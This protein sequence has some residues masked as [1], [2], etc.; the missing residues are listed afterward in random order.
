MGNSSNKHNIQNDTYEINSDSIASHIQLKGHKATR[1][2]ACKVVPLSTNISMII[3][4][5]HGTDAAYTTQKSR[6]EI[7]GEVNIWLIWYNKKNQECQ[8]FHQLKYEFDIKRITL[9]DIHSSG[10]FIIL[11]AHNPKKIGYNYNFGQYLPSTQAVPCILLS[12]NGINKIG[13][14]EDAQT[15]P[16][17]VQLSI[18]FKYISIQVD[19]KL[20]E[21]GAWNLKFYHF[22]NNEKTNNGKNCNGSYSDMKTDKSVSMDEND[23]S[24]KS[25][26]GVCGAD[27]SINNNNY[28]KWI[29]INSQHIF[30]FSDTID[31]KWIAKIALKEKYTALP[32]DIYYPLKKD[33]FSYDQHKYYV[34][35]DICS[36][37]NNLIYGFGQHDRIVLFKSNISNIIENINNKKNDKEFTP[38]EITPVAEYDYKSNDWQNL[39]VTFGTDGRLFCVGYK[40]TIYIFE[41]VIDDNNINDT[42]HEIKLIGEHSIDNE[43]DRDDDGDTDNDET[44]QQLTHVEMQ[45]DVNVCNLEWI[46]ENTLL[47]CVKIFNKYTNDLKYQLRMLQTLKYDSI[48]INILLPHVSDISDICSLILEMVGSRVSQTIDTSIKG[49]RRIESMSVKQII[50][51]K[52]KFMAVLVACGE[53]DSKSSQII[54]CIMLSTRGI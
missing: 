24:I 3:T 37:N 13:V 47:Y 14:I 45:E 33:P 4:V 44:K 2:H 9:C 42:H 20:L 35:F 16:K 6:N 54:D 8:R 11:L 26:V 38:Y 17:A 49:T 48:R 21:H 23:K 19:T 1:L 25:D 32:N 27:G 52:F 28:P 30:D 29:I 53:K 15:L 50:A 51:S 18:D 40:N 5:G 39:N 7:R 10:E 22:I 12:I 36:S 41:I 43:R 31:V 34:K 46:D